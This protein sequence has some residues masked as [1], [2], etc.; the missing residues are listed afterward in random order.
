[1]SQPKFSLATPDEALQE[2]VGQANHVTLAIWA[3]DC[4]L[5]VLPMYESQ[6]PHNPHPRQALDTLQD[7]ID[8]GEFSISVIRSASLNAHAAAR[9]VNNDTPAK[10]AARAAGQAVATAHVRTHALGATKY[11]QQAA[12]RAA[13]PKDTQQA[14]V[15]ERNWQ[16]NHLKQLITKRQP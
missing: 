10:S 14:V 7:W 12:F 11:A 8:T 16:F 1:M 6:F 9:Q 3:R 13:L 15:Q 4:A 5:R 2:L